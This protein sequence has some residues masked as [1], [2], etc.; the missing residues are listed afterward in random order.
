MTDRHDRHRRPVPRWR[1][2]T[3]GVLLAVT[4][5][6]CGSSGGSEAAGDTATTAVTTTAAADTAT[7]TATKPLRILVTN[8]DGVTAPGIDTIVKALQTVPDATITVVAPKDQQSGQGGKTTAGPLTVTDAK[9]ASGYPA[10]AVDGFP[11]DTIRAA[12]DDLGIEAD[13]VVSGTNS[14]QNLGPLV[15]ISG[16]IGAARAAAAKGL[17]ALAVSTGAGPNG[18]DFEASVPFVLDWVNAH[19]DAAIAGTAPAQVDNLN[20]P[21]CADGTKVRGEVKVIATTEHGDGAIKPQDCAS[22]GTS[23]DN[24][25]EAFNN[26]FATLTEKLQPVKG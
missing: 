13:L 25:V 3:V 1:A 18:F 24:D 8:D 17:P 6:A 20:V 22:T 7:T 21:S 5:A 4:M 10:K 23:Y 11:A 15:D 12:I 9:T 14:G 19:R 2:A 26:G 16:T